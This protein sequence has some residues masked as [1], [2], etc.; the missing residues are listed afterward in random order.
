MERPL[1]IVLMALS[2]AALLGCRTQPATLRVAT[3]NI[4]EFSL[5]KIRNVDG[6][7]VGQ[8][9][10]LRAAATIIQRI[11][12]DILVLNEI[13]HEYG[14]FDVDCTGPAQAFI[15][16]Y[17]KTGDTPINY[18]YVYAAPCNTGIPSGKDLNKDGYTAQLG[19]ERS[20][21]FAA[22]CF[23]WGEYPGQYSMALLSRY[24]IDAEAARTFQTFLW[25]DLP[26]NH[27][28]QDYY[29]DNA[30]GLRLSSKSHWDV[31]V[32]VGDRTLRMLMSHPTPPAFDGDEDRNGRRN[33]DELNFWVRYLENDP[34]LV[35][36]A[37]V[38]GGF[39]GGEPFLFAGDFNADPADA[40]VYEGVTAIGQLLHHPKVRDT[41]E[42]LT[43]EGGAEGRPGGPPAHPER[44]TAKFGRDNRVRIDYLLPSKDVEVAT[45]GVF[46]SSSE[47]DPQGA[48]LAD[49]ASDHRLTWLDIRLPQSPKSKE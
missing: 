8:D 22:D 5:D 35:D 46:W 23:G 24:P 20:T 26:G 19:D 17:L 14:Q 21:R 30:E 39:I 9:E 47:D 27:L 6:H 49:R 11:R 41:G 3:F 18:P 31:P 44:Y 34:A 13:D 48:A 40:A 32:R 25:K 12:P 37:G 7:G 4:K 33:F 45:G 38:A 29:G 1:L 16:A 2:L 36:D 10:Q 15:Q 43:S 28:P 42:F